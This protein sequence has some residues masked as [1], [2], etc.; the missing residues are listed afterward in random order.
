MKIHLL[1]FLASI[2]VLSDGQALAAKALRV[3]ADPDYLPYSNEAG[4]GFENKIAD[5]VAKFMGTTVEYTWRSSRDHGGF[6]QFLVNTLDASKCDVI[7]SVP[8]G[9]PE[10]GTTQPYY[11][12]SYV[13]VF[14]K[15]KNYNIDSMNSSVLKALRVGFEEDTPAEDALKIRGM[16]PKAV[17]FDVGS[18][19]DQS[20]EDMLKAVAD[21]KVDVLITWEPAIGKFI[22]KYPG[23]EI[24]PIPNDRAL[25]P[26]ERF[27]FPM[28]MGV[29]QNDD[30]LKSTLDE[31]ITK[32]G[33]ELTAILER[34]GV[35]RYPPKDP[36]TP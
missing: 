6:P 33:A 3:C 32:H 2:A 7:I 22:S 4:Q 14:K 34:E 12:S 9:S 35:K 8:Y 16:L 36:N 20:P 10:E 30:A 11:T 23:F 1:L 13:F 29:R 25:G 19:K 5:A 21:D 24:V 31:V 15:S 28:S 18:E 17:R 26:P 27:S